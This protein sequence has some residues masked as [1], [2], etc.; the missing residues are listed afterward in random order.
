M[1]ANGVDA[2][3]VPVVGG[4]KKTPICDVRIDHNQ[5]W[6]N[7][8]W[9]AIQSAYGRAPFFEY[10]AAEF[11]EILHRKQS[12]L[13]D[14]SLELLTQC[15]TF[16]QLDIELIFTEEYESLKN[17][18]EIDFRDIISPKSNQILPVTYTQQIYQ[19]VFG[20]EFVEHLSILDLLFCE[21]PQS[22]LIIKSGIGKG[23]Q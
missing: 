12:F 8:H 5:K 2:L 9:R 10:Y 13:F 6:I 20:S 4:S 16:L 22:G 1:G 11:S 21:G 23:T 14:L 15:L 7:R 18:P 19:Q 17:R 3:S